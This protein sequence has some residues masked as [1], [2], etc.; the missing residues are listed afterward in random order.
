MN[1]ILF[2]AF[3]RVFGVQY[4]S[5][6]FVDVVEL[7][8]DILPN[9]YPYIPVAGG[10][11]SGGEYCQGLTQDDAGGLRYLLA[12]NNINLEVLVPG[13]RGTGTNAANFVNGALRPGIEKL[14]FIRQ[15]YDP[16]LGWTTPVTNEFTDTCFTNGIAMHQQVQRVIT[17]PDFLFCATNTGEYSSWIPFC[18]RTGTTNWWN[19]APSAGSTNN[20]PGVTR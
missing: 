3:H 9:S 4:S 16:I 1:E 14:A 18:G 17:E 7:P 10:G 8:V 6:D 12:S 2:T 20:G 19:S 13:V 5:L 11:W 15:D